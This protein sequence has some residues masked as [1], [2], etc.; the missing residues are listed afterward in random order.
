LSHCHSTAK[1]C[2]LTSLSVIRVTGADSAK[3]LQGQLTCD[4]NNIIELQG[5][6]AAFCNAK[7]RV[8]TNLLILKS[9]DSFFLILPSSLLDKVIKK[10]QIYILRAKVQLSSLDDDLNLFG[11][12]LSDT[13]LNLQQT[14]SD[15]ALKIISHSPLPWS[16]T[17]YF[18]IGT[19]NITPLPT[20]LIS[21]SE[22][23]WRFQDISAGIPWFEA[24]QSELFTPHMLSLDRLGGISFSKGCY[25]GQEI[26]ARTHYLGQAKRN[27]FIAEA[28]N[29][30]ETPLAGIN[31]LAADSGEIVG[32]LLLAETFSQISRMLL[33]LQS[34]LAQ[35]NNL[36][37][38][39]GKRTDIKIVSLQ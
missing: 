11:L 9:Q 31:I 6:I 35:H 39:D 26:V 19:D 5:S 23:E 14:L 3:F 7:G 28:A 37:L 21:N 15:S 33:V 1:I 22:H 10:L 13:A 34:E 12:D 2:K 27:L 4:V 38:D 16:S 18:L 25:T 36:V 17:R 32:S 30:E 24:E 29:T 20:T 8:I